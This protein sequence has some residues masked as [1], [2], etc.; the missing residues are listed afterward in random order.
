MVA[1]L[2]RLSYPQEAIEL[3]LYDYQLDV[4]RAFETHPYAAFC[5]GTGV[6]KS[7]LAVRWSAIQAI[8]AKANTE[9]LAMSP[10]SYMA[11]LHL[12]PKTVLALNEWGFEQKKHFDVN[13]AYRTITFRHNNARIF[14][15][16]AD[17]HHGIQGNVFSTTMCD[18]AGLYNDAA[19]KTIQQR[20]N[21]H[22]GP[23]LYISTPYYWNWYKEEFEKGQDPNNI[24]IK[25]IRVPTWENPDYDRDSIREAAQNWPRWKFDMMYRG[26]FTRPMGAI[27][28]QAVHC[29]CE[30]FPIPDFWPQWGA[31]DFGSTHPTGIL[32]FAQDPLSG[33]IFVTRE[34]RESGVDSQRINDAIKQDRLVYY[35][36]PA[37]AIT[38]NTLNSY[39]N[40]VQLAV[41]KVIDGVMEVSTLLNS[42]GL[43]IFKSCEKLLD[44]TT[45]YMW[46]MDRNER[47]KDEPDKAKGKDDL[48]DTLRYGINSWIADPPMLTPGGAT[49]ARTGSVFGATKK[50]RSW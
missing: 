34:W 10:Y 29:T 6:G 23:T 15:K 42:G 46:K 35:G 50:R 2:N 20:R 5:A 32:W 17:N 1:A 45:G 22:N 18:E 47:P 40:N 24:T 8:Q 19:H 28:P 31:I 33:R 16:G 27:W 37:Q 4:W 30:P 44:E 43:I 13:I 25:S 38:I 36:D 7:H 21:F 3:D 9:H 26:L 41:K 49:V 39:G 11:G 48:C 12:L 14:F